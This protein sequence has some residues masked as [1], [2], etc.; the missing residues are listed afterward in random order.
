MPTVQ[1]CLASVQRQLPT[2]TTS[3]SNSNHPMVNLYDNW[4]VSTGLFTEP[5]KLKNIDFRNNFFRS[6]FFSLLRT[7]DKIAKLDNWHMESAMHNTKTNITDP[8]FNLY[9]HVLERW[10]TEIA[11]NTWDTASQIFIRRELWNLNKLKNWYL[12]NASYTWREL[13]KAFDQEEENG[14]QEGALDDRPNALKSSITQAISGY[15]ADNPFLPQ[16]EN[17]SIQHLLQIIKKNGINYLATREG[18]II[19][20]NKTTKKLFLDGNVRYRFIYGYPYTANATGDTALFVK[21]DTILVIDDNAILEISDKDTITW[22]DYSDDTFDKNFI[23]IYKGKNADG[24]PIIAIY[25]DL[26]AR[27]SSGSSGVDARF[28]VIIGNNND[29]ESIRVTTRGSGYASGDVLTIAKEKM[30][31]GN[32]D[33]KITLQDPNCAKF[34]ITTRQ[35][36]NIVKVG[37]HPIISLAYTNTNTSLTPIVVKLHFEIKK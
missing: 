35:D 15:T 8:S 37:D 30:G 17:A 22:S 24:T 12:S 20:F 31:G 13:L 18:R 5:K 6:G 14:I 2:V 19:D 36:L 28:M 1:I 9:N 33:L 10:N 29:V 21:T 7:D 4:K 32:Q 3:E 27:A 34:P 26:T 11:L 25:S 23:E 16:N